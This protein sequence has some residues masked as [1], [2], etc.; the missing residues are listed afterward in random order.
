MDRIIEYYFNNKLY[1]KCSYNK[2]DYT[3]GNIKGDVVE[4]RIYKGIS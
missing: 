2:W 3:I 1:S 4:E